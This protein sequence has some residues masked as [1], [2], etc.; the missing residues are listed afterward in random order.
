MFGEESLE[1][2]NIPGRVP[3]NRFIVTLHPTADIAHISH[4]HGVEHIRPLQGL[5]HTHVVEVPHSAFDLLDVFDCPPKALE[6]R[7]M[8][9]V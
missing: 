9:T 1:L 8:I 2:G 6:P 3:T 5:A 7:T 4:K